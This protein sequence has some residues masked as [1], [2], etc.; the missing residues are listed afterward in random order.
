M[1]KLIAVLAVFVL[2]VSVAMAQAPSAEN[3]Q[4]VNTEE[5]MP[6]Q[7]SDATPNAKMAKKGCCAAKADGAKAGKGCHGEAKAMKAEKG[8]ADKASATGKS[9]CANKG[10]RAQNMK[11][12]EGE[13]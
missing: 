3:I 8:C 9:C 11:E 4:E 13:E 7:V 12:E 10:M 2:M 5:V 1:K 6:E